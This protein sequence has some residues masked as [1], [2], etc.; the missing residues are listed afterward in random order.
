MGLKKFVM[1]R[2]HLVI[3]GDNSRHVAQSHVLEAFVY[4][5]NRGAQVWFLTDLQELDG[6]LGRLRQGGH[7]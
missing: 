1:Y 5:T 7:P 3:L 6:R 4:E 2:R